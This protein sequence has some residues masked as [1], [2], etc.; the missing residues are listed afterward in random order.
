M[1]ED[2]MT[3]EPLPFNLI[4]ALAKD[5]DAGS[6]RQLLSQRRLPAF[7]GDPQETALNYRPSPQLLLAIN[8]ALHTGSP[9]LLTGEAGTGKTRAADFVGAYFGINVHSFVVKSTSVAQDL[10]YDFDTRCARRSYRDR[11]VAFPILSGI[12]S[13]PRRAEDAARRAA[14]QGP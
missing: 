10:M 11:A 13:R 12:A 5:H 4:E 2:T 7:V 9:L 3:N 14:H 6:R 8:M 1:T